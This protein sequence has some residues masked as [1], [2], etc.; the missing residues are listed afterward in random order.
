M[1]NGI[2]SF[3]SLHKIRC[4]LSCP[5]LRSRTFS[6]SFGSHPEQDKI[7][8]PVSRSMWYPRGYCEVEELIRK[9]SP[10]DFFS[11]AVCPG[12]E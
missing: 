6:N 9:L 12:V 1:N 10:S 3:R 11:G 2:L 8:R 7:E 4:I 5:S